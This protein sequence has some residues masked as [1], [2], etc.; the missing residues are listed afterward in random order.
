[1]GFKGTRSKMK[2][3]PEVHI[4]ELESI[5]NLPPGIWLPVSYI[6]NEF[7]VTAQTIR[8]LHQTGQIRAVKIREMKV[9]LFN[10]Q[11]VK[12]AYYE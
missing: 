1:M 12:K 5:F 11:D 3:N 10:A 6:A 9:M 4:A 2:N 7:E 8:N